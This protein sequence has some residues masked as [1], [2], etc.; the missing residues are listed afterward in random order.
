VNLGE[1]GAFL[2][3]RRDRIR[4]GE[5]GLPA[6][7]RRRVPGLRREEVAQLAGASADYYIELERGAGVQPSE[8][9]LAALARALRLGRDERDH[10]FRLAGRPVPASG[11]AADHVHPS[12][13]DLMERLDGTPAQVVTDLR[14]VLVQNRLAAALLGANPRGSFVHRWFT[15]P[16]ERALYPPEDHEEQSRAFVADLRVVAARRGEGDREV[17]ALVTGLL[18]RS[19]EFAGLWERHDVA[20]QR[21][22]RKRLVH[23]QLGL[24]EVNCLNLF[25]EDQRQRLL[26]FTPVAGTGAAAKLELLAVLGT[27]ELE[28]S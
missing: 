7:P 16:A 15:D 18:A 12:L 20:V 1:L 6:G 21:H 13:L 3:A 25:S 10:L 2:K 17:K 26:W 14:V 4:P 8:Q 11:G 19:P 23:P 24:L 28:P 27:Q 9:M 5:A 22:D